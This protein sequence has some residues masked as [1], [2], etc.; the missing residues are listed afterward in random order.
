MI[1]YLGTY[2]E[3]YFIDV[4][5]DVDHFA[6]GICHYVR[7]VN[8]GS[9]I[10]CSRVCIFKLSVDSTKLLPKKIELIIPFWSV[11]S[12]AFVI[13]QYQAHC[14]NTVAAPNIE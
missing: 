10:A 11:G 3:R 5:M 9:G 13:I 1:I 8:L 2:I 7:E 6:H 14:Q 12:D 4:L